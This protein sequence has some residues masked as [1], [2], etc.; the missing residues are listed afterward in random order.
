[1]FW[2]VIHTKPRQELRALQ[3]LQQQGYECY[4]PLLPVERLQRGAVVQAQEALFP[5]YLFVKLDPSM[6]GKSW[7]PIRSTKGVSRLVS[8]GGQ[9]A[10]VDEALV[11]GLQ[12]AE[13]LRGPQALFQAGDRVE[14]VGG[15]FSGLD[16][17][18]EMRDGEA[19]ALVL[20]EMLS[21]PVRLRVSPA[22]LRRVV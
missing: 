7:T 13:R 1:M 10:P 20:I 17:I 22:N 12:R 18:Y 4:L 11:L 6:Q 8:F 19:R 5:R 14:V 16:A 9:P 15:A 3:N 2:F 21:K